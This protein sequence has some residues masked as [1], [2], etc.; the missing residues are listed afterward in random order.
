LRCDRVFKIVVVLSALDLDRQLPSYSVQIF[1][2]RIWNNRNCEIA[3]ARGH[4]R[5]V[6]KDERSLATLD[7]AAEF[8][9]RDVTGGTGFE[10]T[11][12]QHLAPAGTD[13]LTL[14]LLIDRHSSHRRIA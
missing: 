2:S 6:L 11:A 4:R 7:C 3:L 8:F 9:H 1:S 13:H 10:I 12:R 14:P 5:G